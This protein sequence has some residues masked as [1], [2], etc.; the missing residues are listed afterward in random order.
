MNGLISYTPW[1]AAFILLLSVLRASA[2]GE[3]PQ[4]RPAEEEGNPKALREGPAAALLSVGLDASDGNTER[5]IQSPK[6]LAYHIDLKRPTRMHWN[7][8]RR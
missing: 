2:D 3:P 8:T 6:I 5:R 7:L 1:G 4:N